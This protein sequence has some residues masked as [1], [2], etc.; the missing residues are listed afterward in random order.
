MAEQQPPQSPPSQQHEQEHPESPVTPIPYELANQVDYNRDLITI[1]TN[2]EVATLYLEHT[3]A[4]YFKW[5]KTGG[6]DQISSKDALILYCLKNGVKNDFAKVIWDD[7]LSKL[8]K[9]HIEKVVLYSRLISLLVEHKMKETYENPEATTIHTLIFNVKNWTLNDDELSWFRL[10]STFIGPLTKEATEALKG[11]SKKRKKSVTAKD[12]SPSQP[13]V[14]TLVV[15][16]MHKE[17]LQATSV[18][19]SLGGTGEERADPQL[20]SVDSTSQKAGDPSVPSTGQ[21]GTHPTKGEK[22]TRQFTIT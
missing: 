7:L 12:K 3:N 5:R 2:N 14:S 17:A 6:Y 19:T 8:Q 9:K 11:H 1:R 10:E 15:T 13:L 18:Q 4:D 21:V 20:I 22:N 16:E